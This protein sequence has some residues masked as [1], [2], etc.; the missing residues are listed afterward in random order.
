MADV[1]RTEV[2]RRYESECY[3]ICCRLLDDDKLA[4]SA[5]QSVFI[6]LYQEPSFFAASRQVQL[7]MLLKESFRCC[8]GY[9]TVTGP[10][11]AGA[12]A[13]AV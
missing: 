12:G 5:A 4:Q 13:A 6:N 1:T 7:K 9:V 2:L 3:Q 11:V 10:A 8:A